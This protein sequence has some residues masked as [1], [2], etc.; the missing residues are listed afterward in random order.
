MTFPCAVERRAVPFR[1]WQ[2][3]WDGGVWHEALSRRLCR[4]HVAV[5]GGEVFLQVHG[6][7]GGGCGGL[8]HR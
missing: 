2:G 8:L 1:E 7:E 4:L 6:W 3:V 5:V